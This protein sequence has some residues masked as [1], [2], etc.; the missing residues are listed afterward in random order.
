M[1][2]L[3]P[4]PNEPLMSGFEEL[5]DAVDDL[6]G[7]APNAVGIMLVVGL[8]AHDLC[9]LANPVEDPPFE[10]HA[11]VEYRVQP[12]SVNSTSVP[13]VPFFG[14]VDSADVA[15]RAAYARRNA[16]ARIAQMMYTTD[17][18]WSDLFPKK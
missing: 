5:K 4:P 14:A 7:A 2:V 8:V 16:Q 9:P 17:D 10:N 15:I 3:L 11:P 6:K 1:G 13:D 12:I 18:A